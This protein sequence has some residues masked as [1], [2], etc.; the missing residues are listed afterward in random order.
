MS[1]RTIFRMPSSLS[2]PKCSG[3]AITAAPINPPI[4]ACDELLGS[5]TY[6]V[7]RFHTM[8]AS[9]AAIT[10]IGVSAD[11]SATSVPMV[12][13][14]W[15]LMNAPRKLRI[16]AIIMATRGE[17]TR[18][19]TLVAMAFAVSWKPFVKSKAT[20]TRIVRIRK[21]RLTLSPVLALTAASSGSGRWMRSG[22]F[23]QHPMEYIGN[24][25]AA[26]D[27]ALQ[28]VVHLLPFENDQRV[29]LQK[30]C[31]DRVAV[32]FVTLIFEAVDLGE[33][34][35]KHRAIFIESAQMRDGLL[36]LHAG[37]HNK[38]RQF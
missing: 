28:M 30:Q 7:S 26:I 12:L 25:F 10:A 11:G 4:S 34:I 2:A 27:G 38:L 37:L 13:A 35:T 22:I 6:H 1:A 9:S 16:A 31:L 29:G 36:H 24:I 5:P 21:A 8:A 20:A 14:T 3:E 15:V 19:E 32:H 23:Q 18:V 33:P 17:R